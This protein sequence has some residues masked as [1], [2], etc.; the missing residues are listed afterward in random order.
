[1]DDLDRSAMRRVSRAVQE[2]VIADGGLHCETIDYALLVQL[3]HLIYVEVQDKAA[4]AAM[5][6][7]AY[8]TLSASRPTAEN[9]NLDIRVME[10]W[11][12]EH[13]QRWG[14]CLTRTL[15][16]HLTLCIDGLISHGVDQEEWDST[17]ASVVEALPS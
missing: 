12:E 16:N 15:Q 2:E 13:R 11:W 8:A 14:D 5:V 7:S 9:E 10:P 4:V 17:M 1:V 6:N 3:M